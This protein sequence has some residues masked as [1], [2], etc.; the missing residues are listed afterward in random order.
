MFGIYL[1]VRFVEFLVSIAGP[2]FSKGC[3]L[4]WYIK[5]IPLSIPNGVDAL[6]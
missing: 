6:L 4:Y 5:L 3:D 1:L 2:K